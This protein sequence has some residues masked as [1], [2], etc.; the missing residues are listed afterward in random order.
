LSSKKQSEAQP[1]RQAVTRADLENS[2]VEAVRAAHPEF[3]HFT[4]VIVERVEPKASGGVNWALKGVRFG[5]ADRHRCGIVLSYCVEQAERE[6]EV[7]D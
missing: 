6:F 3:E 4:G 2:L 5:R 1:T 7:S